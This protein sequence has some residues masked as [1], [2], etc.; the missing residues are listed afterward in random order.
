MQKAIAIPE[1]IAR[2][3][4]QD[5]TKAIEFIRIWGE[6]RMAITKLYSLLI[7]ELGES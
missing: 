1:L 3:S 7:E 5:Q 6:K 2:L 4:Y